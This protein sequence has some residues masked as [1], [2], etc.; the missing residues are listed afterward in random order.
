VDRRGS[1]RRAL[2]VVGF[3]GVLIGGTAACTTPP[4]QPGTVRNFI[5]GVRDDASPDSVAD[6]RARRGVGVSARWRSAMRGFLASM[7]DDDARDLAADP[8]VAFVEPDIE[9]SIQA[10]TVPTG[11][12]RAGAAANANLRLNG[13]VDGDVEADVAVLDTGIDLAHTDL[14][15]GPGVVCTNGSCRSGGQDDHGHGTHV[16]GTIGAKDDGNGV[17]GVAPGA[18]VVP[19]KSLG[20]NGSGS[21]SNIVAGLNWV[22]EQSGR[23]EAVNMSLG[24]PGIS[25]ALTNAITNLT[26]RGVVV[27]VAA[28]NS[29]RN[30][31]N[32]VPANNTDVIAVSAIA[33]YNGRA[34]GGGATTCRNAGVDD[35]KA[36]FSNFGNVVDIAAPGVCIL[37]TRRGGGTTTMS[38]TSMASPHVAGAA[39]LLASRNK[40]TNRAGV[41]ALRNTLLSSGTTDWTDT[42]S[43]GIREPLLNVS[44]PSL[45][46]PMLSGG[47]STPPPSTT[48]TTTPSPGSSTTTT[49][50]PTSPPPPPPPTVNLSV[51][52]STWLFL[53]YATLSWSGLS[54][55]TVTVY[56]NGVAQSA[57]NTGQFVDVLSLFTRSATYRVCAAGTTTCSQTVTATF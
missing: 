7:S 34:G 50:T 42:S 20:S 23:I 13:L 4:A 14:R 15:V 32:I 41:T 48:T 57:P 37:S 22:A 49:T 44:N 2:G 9:V 21:M 47:P 33:D 11:V 40:P 45:Y 55:S 5:V 10:Q 46:N 52:T 56:V 18:R 26:N 17:V 24:G 36:S 1:A 27:V 35:R 51:G 54:G 39:A 25:T 16:A 28:G 3:A 12:N 6:E 43:D 30:S 19:V 38:G 53:R 29:N 8:R 31:S